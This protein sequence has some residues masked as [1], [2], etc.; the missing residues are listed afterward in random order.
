LQLL[1]EVNDRDDSELG[2]QEPVDD[3]VGRLV[4]LFQWF[5]WVLVD[6]MTSGGGKSRSLDT[7]DEACRHPIGIKFRILGDE[8]LNRPQ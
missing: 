7:F 6:W 8:L 5:F 1:L 3:A 4:N 2:V